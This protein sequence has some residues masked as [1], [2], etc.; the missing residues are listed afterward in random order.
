M[1]QIQTINNQLTVSLFKLG[2]HL[3]GKS[4]EINIYPIH[5]AVLACLVVTF[6]GDCCEMFALLFFSIFPHIPSPLPLP[7]CD[8]TTKRLTSLY[9]KCSGTIRKYVFCF[10][11]RWSLSQ[12]SLALILR[13][14]MNVVVFLEFCMY[15]V[16]RA[17]C[18]NKIKHL[19][20]FTELRLCYQTFGCLFA[21]NN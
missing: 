2:E 12:W 5:L 20:W 13:V 9:H 1:Q 6:I 7:H 14:Q 19:P 21:F 17:T 4:V 16:K 11:R 3:W 18:V 15:E 8:L 10:V